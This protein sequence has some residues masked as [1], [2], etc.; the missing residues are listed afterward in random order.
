[1]SKFLLGARRFILKNSQIADITPLQIYASSLIF[2]PG[3]A[4]TRSKFER[5]LPD[6][7]ERGPRVEE[8]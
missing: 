4:I 5:E 8:N 3:K 6:W 7:I 1:M 2:A